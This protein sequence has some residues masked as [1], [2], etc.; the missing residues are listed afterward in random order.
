MLSFRWGRSWMEVELVSAQLQ[1]TLVSLN[2]SGVELYGFQQKDLLT[3]TF[4]IERPDFERVKWIC[5]KENGKLRMIRRVGLY[6]IWQ[7]ICHRFVLVMGLL[8]VFLLTALV[9]SRVFF[10]KVEGNDMVPTRQ[11]LSA[12]EMCGIGFGASRRAVR[13]EKVKNALLSSV[14]QLQWAGINTSGCVA[15]ISVRERSR[16][17]KAEKSDGVSS[18]IADRDGYIL[19]ASASRGR[20]LVHPGETVQSGQVLISGYTDCGLVIRA[21][22]AEG[23]VYAQTNRVLQLIM[24]SCYLEKQYT[25][26]Q[27]KKISLLIGKKRINL[28]KDSGISPTSCGRMYEEYYVTLPGDFCLPAALCIERYPEYVLQ[29]TKAEEK[30]LDAEVSAYAKE[31]LQ[32]QMAAGKILRDSF[33]VNYQTERIFCEGSFV[34]Q[35][36]IGRVQMEQIGEANG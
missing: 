2:A 27:K 15:T 24:P 9:P 12:A 7:S 3:G 29:E 19:S 21:Q 28:W 31:Y 1:K 8:L 26:G 17:R 33:T 35:E 32:Q 30:T 13:S 23:E 16:E 25:G 5:E 14:P 22:R 18:I 4:W 6:W 34:C 11:I 36:M 10:V 20:L